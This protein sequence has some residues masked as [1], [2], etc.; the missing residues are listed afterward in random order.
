[1]SLKIVAVMAAL[2][3]FASSCGDD[4]GG[5]AASADDPLVQAIVDDIMSEADGLTTE[6]AEAECFV[7]GVVGE[8]GTARL[9]ELG[10]TETN[11]AGLD[12]IDWTEDEAGSVVDR[13]FACVDVS[14]SFIEQNDFGELDA[15]QTE[16]VR[17]VFT[18]ENLKPAL[19]SLYSGEDAEAGLFELFSQVSDCGINPFGS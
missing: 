8:I 11:I 12:E 5:S 19:V 15:A 4:G 14:D 10:V 13:L 6:R 9:N 16:C 3:L 2:L 7:S 17:G 1:M 18:E